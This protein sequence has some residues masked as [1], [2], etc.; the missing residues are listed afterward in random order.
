MLSQKGPKAM[1]HTKGEWV[2]KDR[3][4]LAKCFTGEYKNICDKV[5]GGNPVEADANT[6]LIA[7]APMMW[8]ELKLAADTFRDFSLVLQ[9]IGKDTMAAAAGIAERHIREQLNNIADRA[10]G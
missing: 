5:R 2:G 8:E 3:V 1:N 9:K 10:S 6:R 4:V 7:A